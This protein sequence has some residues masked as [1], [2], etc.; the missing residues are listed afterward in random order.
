MKTIISSIIILALSTGL[1]F[2]QYDSPQKLADSYQSLH[3]SKDLEEITALFYS[4]DAA[5]IAVSSIREIL[6]SEFK[7]DVTIDKIIVKEIS[8]E[9]RQR[10]TNGYPYKGKL[11]VPTINNLT[12]TMELKFATSDP[13]TFD[14]SA[15]IH[16]GRTDSGYM[17]T[18]SKLIEPN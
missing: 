7:S 13:D 18:L 15:K 17:L 9:E 10:M 12:H 3:A 1:V 14:Q 11:L 6:I 4:K 2:G 5:P 16:F 8:E